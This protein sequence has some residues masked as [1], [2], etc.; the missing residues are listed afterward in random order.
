MSVNTTLTIETIQRYIDIKIDELKE[1]QNSTKFDNISNE[2]L[3]ND[4]MSIIDT[5]TFKE[6]ILKELK[7]SIQNDSNSSINSEYFT[8]KKEFNNLVQLVQNN[9]TIIINIK[10][11]FIEAK[12]SFDDYIKTFNEKTFE[13]LKIQDE[14]IKVITSNINNLHTNIMNDINSIQNA[15]KSN[16]TTIGSINEIVTSNNNDLQIMKKST[17]EKF[18]DIIDQINELNQSLVHSF[19]I[20]EF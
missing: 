10:K 15:T 8:I 6:N 19:K 16:S 12:Q 9:N 2:L 20:E 3:S 17:S 5:N 18:Q 7:E 13:I 1:N 11:E 14:K 4:T